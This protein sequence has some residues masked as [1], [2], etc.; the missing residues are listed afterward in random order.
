MSYIKFDKNHLI[1]L[2]YSLPLELLRSNRAG[3]WASQ[4]IIGC[5]TR[6]YHGLL[7]CPQPAIDD[8]NHVLLSNLDET[9][10]QNDAE[11][12][13]GIHRYKG[14]YFTPKG[15]KYLREFELDPIPKVT[16]R[17]G[18]GI[19][20]R[21]L[22]FSTL[23]DRI[24]LKYTLVDAHS[25]TIIRLK[26]FLAFRNAHFLTHANCQA[27][28]SF[29]EV[30]NG[31]SIKLYDGYTPLVMQLSKEVR[32]VHAPD[33]YYNIEYQKEMTRGYD[34]YEDLLVS[35]YF[36]FSL[37]KGESII[38]SAGTA[39]IDHTLL[40]RKF[41]EESD[42][43]IPRDNFEN[44][45]KNAAQQFVQ[46]DSPEATYIVAG[47]PFFG[48]QSRET[49]MALPGLTL[50]SHDR[51]ICRSVIDTVV[52]NLNG[53]LLPFR[54]KSRQPTYNAVD[55][56]LWL[57]WTLQH[58][59]SK[60][61]PKSS[62]WKIYGVSLK[63]ILNG[64]RQGTLYGIVMQEDGLL[65]AGQA[66]LA[67]TWM[68]TI[69]DG[70]LVTPRIGCAIEVNALWYNAICFALEL[71]REA[72][73]TVFIEEWAPL[74]EKA[75]KSMLSA[76]WSEH[77]G[78]LA[79]VID[80]ETKDWTMRPNQILATSLPYTPF[81]EDQRKSILSAVRHELLT[82]RGIRTLSPQ[83]PDYKGVYQGSQRE[84]DLAY[85]QGT[86]FPWLLG[87]FAEG[88]LRIHGKSGLH[89]IK[90]L[91]SG[92]EDEISNHGIGSISEM[93]DGDPP[94]KACG[95]ISHSISVAE[96]LRMKVIIDQFET[97]SNF[98]S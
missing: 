49:L 80:G 85:H 65:R 41:R 26:P 1:N 64:M 52:K 62:L 37:T 68:D 7:V 61:D 27:D 66:G 60:F 34:F 74:A 48:N 2:E 39:Q 93:F 33:W 19:F 5:N 92:F 58:M 3:A 53:A 91:Y 43:R 72:K 36:E 86:V 4:T 79:D 96:L 16:Y 56:P 28:T 35:G 71:A 84:R 17:I 20:T 73:D 87:H 81:S 42:R 6:R 11:F 18:G 57:F 40:K 54:F 69:V 10:I 9:I 95:A 55:P 47:F 94:H 77:R 82:P 67:L 32:Y 90:G 25:H 14:G 98:N 31:I 63:Q 44:S 12:N 70:R 50:D 88:Y 75:G 46:S 76:F 15:H 23:E 24:L 8:D 22:L 83:H 59:R 13:L 89:F 45:L 29:T 51:K 38:F 21:E 97:K 30:P 78:F